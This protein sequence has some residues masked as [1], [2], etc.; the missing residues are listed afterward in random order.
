M[1]SGALFSVIVPT[2]NRPEQL[3]RAL[4]SV[5]RQSLKDF[6]LIVVDDG[7]DTSYVDQVVQQARC[8]KVRIIRQV[9]NR[10][11]AAARNAGVAASTGELIAF[12]DDDDQFADEFLAVTAKAFLNAG[13]RIGASWSAVESTTQTYEFFGRYAP[14]VEEPADDHKF[15]SEFLAAGA[16]CGLTIRMNCLKAIGGFNEAFR[17]GEDTELFVRMLAAGYRPVR[18]PPDLVLVERNAGG[19]LT[20]K[21][22]LARRREAYQWI[23]ATYAEFLAT[24]PKLS[25]YL[26]PHSLSDIWRAQPQTVNQ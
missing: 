6:E 20:T 16:G 21:A 14:V 17:I 12:L 25:E 5:E 1:A 23:R 4:K 2:Y 26:S 7:S 10:G 3:E 13:S 22:T 18:L 11:P 9:V 8:P 19:S 15:L 24:Q